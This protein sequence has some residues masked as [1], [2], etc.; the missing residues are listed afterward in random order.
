MGRGIRNM[1]QLNREKKNLLLWKT[2]EK[3]DEWGT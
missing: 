2:G 3:E 1:A